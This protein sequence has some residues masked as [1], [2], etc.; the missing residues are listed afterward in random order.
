MND[1]LNAWAGNQTDIELDI[2]K[3]VKAINYMGIKLNFRYGNEL[4]M[5]LIINNA[6]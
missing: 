5:G 2:R 3:N 4:D 6:E 1:G